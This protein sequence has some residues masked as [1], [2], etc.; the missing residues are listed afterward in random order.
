MNMI[1][2]SR[3]KTLLWLIWP[4]LALLLMNSFEDA[5]NRSGTWSISWQVTMVPLAIALLSALIY[6]ASRKRAFGIIAIVLCAVSMLTVLYTYNFRLQ[7]LI[8]AYNRIRD[9]GPLP[10]LL[11][12]MKEGLSFSV[13]GFAFGELLFAGM[14]YALPLLCMILF[15]V[16]T[17]KCVKL[18][19][20]KPARVAP[21][22][23]AQATS[24]AMSAKAAVEKLK[25]LGKL[26][27]LGVLTDEEFQQKKVDLLSR[28]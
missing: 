4:V 9:Y 19:E 18:V 25:E 15:F 23:A 10:G 24:S 14:M 28:I 12:L 22:R 17:K 13:L 5:L 21:P 2:K 20:K 3:R 8:D 26:H 6:H 1:E 7:K 11:R 27:R 16:R